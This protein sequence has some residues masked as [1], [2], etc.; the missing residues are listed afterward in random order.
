M[1]PVA[2]V[3]MNLIVKCSIFSI[4]DDEDTESHPLHTNDWMNSQGTAEDTKCGRNCLTPG[5]DGCL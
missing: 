2:A 3:F 4:K 1:G 5:G